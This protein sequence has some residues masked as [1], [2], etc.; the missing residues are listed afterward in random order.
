[1]FHIVFEPADI[2]IL[3]QA[4]DLDSAL[5]GEIICFEEDYAVGPIL[6]LDK[7]AGWNARRQWISETI[8]TD[9]ATI[10][11]T[12]PDTAAVQQ[13]TGRMQEET[14]DEV[15]IWVC[16][17]A[18]D[19]SGYYWLISQLGAFTGRVFVISLNNLPFINEKGAVFYPAHLYEILPKE[20]RK[21]RRLARPVTAAEF[22]VDPDEWTRLVNENKGLRILE[23]AKKLVQADYDHFDT[24]LKKMIPA[25]GQKAGR[26]I[27]QFLSK[28]NVNI[29]ESFLQW[30]LRVLVS[31]G[32]IADDNG[33]LS[34]VAVETI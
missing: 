3:T 21:A 18:R 13:L 30:R 4:M 29:P 10:P 9:T 32:I 7:P 23:G 1:M 11:E 2:A 26:L 27:H 20:C 19:V 17:N 8:A 14:F 24:P 22:E 15:W 25:E 5:D 16:S 31:T 28:T 34:N 33:L 6:D 12:S